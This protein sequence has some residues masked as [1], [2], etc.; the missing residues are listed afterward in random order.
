MVH[1]VSLLCI[2]YAILLFCFVS[3]EILALIDSFNKKQKKILLEIK[4][5]NKK[6]SDELGKMSKEFD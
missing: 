2:G 1:W 4:L 5:K 3:V 6:L